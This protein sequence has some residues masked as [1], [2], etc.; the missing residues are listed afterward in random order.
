VPR[1]RSRR[2]GRLISLV[3][4][5]IVA[6]LVVYIWRRIPAP[7]PIAL[8][9]STVSV[10]QDN[11]KLEVEKISEK[12]RA[13][14]LNKDINKW[15]SCYASSYPNLGRLENRML[16]IWKNNDIKEVSYRISNVQPLGN[17][18]ATAD[19]IWN[20]QV[21]DHQTHDYTLVRQSYKITLEKGS[22]GWKIRDSKEQGGGSS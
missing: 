21:Y 7:T 12:I 18:Q 16:E 2:P 22:G 10:P 1:R 6:V 8:T 11:L 3:G 13:A 9:P 17:N 5:L 20:I 4:V 14:H 19:I 15:L